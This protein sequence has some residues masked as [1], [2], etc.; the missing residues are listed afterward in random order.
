MIEKAKKTLLTFSF[1]MKEFLLLIFLSALT[2]F[3][4]SFID[5]KEN[6]GILVTFLI[7][8]SVAKVWVLISKT[9]G[10]MASL[11]RKSHNINHTRSAFRQCRFLSC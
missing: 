7:L 2:F 1:L 3:V 9:L 8:F 11:T 5:H 6:Q 4:M 10:K